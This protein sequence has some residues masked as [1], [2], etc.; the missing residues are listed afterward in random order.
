MRKVAQWKTLIPLTIALTGLAFA[1]TA[2]RRTVERANRLYRKGAV[3]EAALLYADRLGRDPTSAQL[4]YNLGTALLALRSEKAGEELARA[5]AAGNE[6]VRARALYNLGS[7]NLSKALNADG[8]GSAKAS[9][10]LAVAAYK[11][12]LRLQPGRA[13]AGWNL[14]IALRVIAS[15][16]AEGRQGAL[17]SA[18]GRVARGGERVLTGDP[19]DVKQVEDIHDGPRTA[20]RETA[21]RP[22]GVA[23]VSLSEAAEILGTGH[24]DPT[25]MVR[26]LMALEGR[27]LRRR[28]S[29]L[30]K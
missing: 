3:Q 1:W 7:W 27:A 2:D 15:A 14:A 20:E 4:R 30:Q 21:A 24:R 26:K 12:L 23:S 22:G 19:P 9:A 5:S 25:M 10:L 8:V 17:T 6:E 11:S 16:D 28:A 18:K 29:E 13:D